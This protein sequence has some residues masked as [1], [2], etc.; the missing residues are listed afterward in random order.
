MIKHRQI[1]KGTSHGKM[2]DEDDEIIGDV[3]KRREFTM[4]IVILIILAVLTVVV[5]VE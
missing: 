4:T 3:A 5:V 2:Y 1:S